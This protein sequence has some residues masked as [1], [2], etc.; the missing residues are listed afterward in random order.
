MT[1]SCSKLSTKNLPYSKCI[2]LMKEM[3]KVNALKK[4][5]WLIKYIWEKMQQEVYDYWKQ[6]PGTVSIDKMQIFE[7]QRLCLVSYLIVKSQCI[8]MLIT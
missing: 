7:D 8:E 1:G 5:K 4:R 3:E 6:Y 2:E